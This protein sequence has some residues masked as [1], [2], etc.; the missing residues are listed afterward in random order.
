VIDEEKQRK[1]E[2]CASSVKL[3]ESVHETLGI[4][5]RAI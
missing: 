4:G 1:S 5:R 3:D 2:D